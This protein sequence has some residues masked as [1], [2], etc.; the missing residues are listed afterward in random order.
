M[1]STKKPHLDPAWIHEDALRII[2]KLQ[3]SGYPTYLVGGCVRDLL[4]GIAPKDF[5]IATTALP[6][7][8]RK[9]IT[10]SYIIGKR[11]R[12]VLA[13]R[14]GQQFEIATFRRNWNST[15]LKEHGE[16]FGDNYFGTPEE[17]AQRRDFTVNGL[18]YDPIKKELI[19]YANSQRDLKSHILRMIGE[20][21]VRLEEDPIRILRGIRLSHKINFSMD[22]AL[23]AAM[24]TKAET[25]AT[26]ALPRRREEYLKFL[27]VKEPHLPWLDCYDLGIL[28]VVAP[29]L[30]E[31]FENQ[32]TH[33]PFLKSLRRFNDYSL[34]KT[35]PVELFGGLIHAYVRAS[36]APDPTKALKAKLLLENK[37]LMTLMKSEL[38]MFNHEQEVVIKALELESILCQ[39]RNFEKKETRKKS[40]IL[41]NQALP[42]SFQ[43]SRRDHLLDPEDHLYWSQLIA[44]QE[45]VANTNKKSKRHRRSKRRRR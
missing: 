5:D 1:K 18:F 30:H 39:R 34:D 43:L 15:D 38:G 41:R 20:P 33:E 17:D 42:L 13:Q 44:N 8:V 14:R 3:S 40:Q 10:R 31:V 2:E 24:A 27:L 9:A 25:L 23:K 12:L 35:S 28:K 6:Q 26:S 37:K 21:N 19:D 32:Q 4:L 22:P 16:T 36:I 29:T 7:E 45:Y 11:F